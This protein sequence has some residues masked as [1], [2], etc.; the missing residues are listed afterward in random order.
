MSKV[1]SFFLFFALLIFGFYLAQHKPLWNDEIYSQVGSIQGQSYFDMLS[2]NIE[3]GSNSPLFYF[4]QK[5][6]CLITQQKLSFS[7]ASNWYIIDKKLQA[8]LRV[9]SNVFMALAI[10]LI[11]YFFTHYY[12]WKAGL[13]AFLVTLSSPMIWRYWVEARPYALWICLTVIQLVLFFTLIKNKDKRA[14][15]WKWF[16]LTH[17]LMAFTA[18]FSL[19]QMVIL[20]MILW[21]FG[22][23]KKWMLP[24]KLYW[25]GTV[26]AIAICLFYY[27]QAPKY[28]FWFDQKNPPLKLLT[29]CFPIEQIVIC[30][31]YGIFFIFFRKGNVAFREEGK[32][33][34]TAL[35]LT[36]LAAGALMGIFIIKAVEY[37]NGFAVV[38]RYFLFLTPISIMVTTLFSVHLMRL[39]KNNFWMTINLSVVLSG[40]LIVRFM[41][42]YLTIYELAIY[43][44]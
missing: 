19:A 8:L 41:K 37:P 40:L 44:K 24:S 28:N 17:I 14:S 20:S 31:I 32:Y 5:T 21:W 29:D 43:W 3:E 38:S 12:S 7:G 25:I 35:V 9:A 26:L 4:I 36:S 33:G 15:L 11:F 30:G 27:T 18:V 10:T 22:R 16:I 23:Q 6:I 13:Y 1:V 2:G 42:T 39:F 34:L